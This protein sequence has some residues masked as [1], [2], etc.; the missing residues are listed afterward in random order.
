ML[1]WVAAFSNGP[2]EIEDIQPPIAPDLTTWLLGL[3]VGSLVLAI[4][5]WRLYPEPQKKAN[6]PPL[7]RDFALGRLEELRVKLRNMS[8][9]QVAI[10]V[11]DVLRGFIE[12][13][14]GIQAVRQT[15]PEFLDEAA[16]RLPLTPSQHD[17]LRQFLRISDDIKFARVEARPDEGETLLEQAFSFVKDEH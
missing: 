8:L 5:A 9:Y 13:Q 15:T 1:W 12:Q 4:I 11:S 16:E 14:Y 3:L 2:D 7:P 10:S 6:P 17:G